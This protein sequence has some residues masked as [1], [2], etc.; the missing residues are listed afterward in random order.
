M[1]VV[2]FNQIAALKHSRMIGSNRLRTRCVTRAIPK[3]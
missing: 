1:E 2:E 3:R